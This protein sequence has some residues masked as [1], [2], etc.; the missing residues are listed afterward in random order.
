MVTQINLDGTDAGRTRPAEPGD[1]VVVRLDETPTSGYRW[2]IEEL[3]P[4]ALRVARDT[5]VPSSGTALG[6]A[7]TREFQLAVVGPR[8]TRLRLALRRAWEPAGAAVRHFE[9]TIDATR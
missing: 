1:L 2:Q 5:F 6:G 3:D 7:G 4:A 8:A 9:T